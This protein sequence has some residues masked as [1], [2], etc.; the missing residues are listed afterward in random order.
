MTKKSLLKWI[1]K[2]GNNPSVLELLREFDK[3]CNELSVR[4]RELLHSKK[5]FIR[6]M[7]KTL[8]KDLTILLED[9][10]STTNLVYDW[11]EML[12]AFRVL[13]RRVVR[14][15]ES[16]IDNRLKMTIKENLKQEIG[17]WQ[18]KVLESAI[19]ELIKG[20]KD[21]QL[22]FMKFEKGEISSVKQK[23]KEGEKREYVRR[24]I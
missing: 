7:D 9:Q 16:G 3:R 21:L 14:M 1:E 12:E 2:G 5:V 22:K 13:R 17:I 15:E 6:A 4:D 11:H 24:C 8:K 19:D 23:P 20:M 18:R 10:T